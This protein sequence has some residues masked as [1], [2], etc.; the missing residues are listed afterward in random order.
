MIFL[1]FDFLFGR[2]GNNSS[3][4]YVAHVFIRNVFSLG[5]DHLIITS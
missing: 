3:I 2:L 1:P 4:T 5:L